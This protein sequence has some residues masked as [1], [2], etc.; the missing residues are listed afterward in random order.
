MLLPDWGST[1]LTGSVNPLCMRTKSDKWA[2]KEG[3]GPLTRARKTRR[4]TLAQV[5][6]RV[7]TTATQVNRLEK[8][9]RRV[10]WDWATRLADALDYDPAY[11]MFGGNPAMV[12]VIGRVDTAGCISQLANSAPH[13]QVVCP[14]G[15]N[16]RTTAALQMD[17]DG[18]SPLAARGW[19]LFLDQT[20]SRPGD[21]AVG[22]WCMV[23]LRGDGT[24]LLRSVRKA[25][26]AGRFN[27][28]SASGQLT[29][30]ADLE[31]AS[32]VRAIVERDLAIAA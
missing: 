4:L 17:G 10:T 15:M 12:P 14:R 11:L 20:P 21:Q 18:L 16:P 31:W 1:E 13:N 27:L 6:E 26:S 32:P 25:P 22:R 9:N 19:Y 30:D 8:N 28:M 3:D 7:G 29:E 5:G 23:R 2:I 24:Q